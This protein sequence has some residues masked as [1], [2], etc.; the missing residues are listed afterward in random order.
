VEKHNEAAAQKVSRKSL[1]K[2]VELLRDI[3]WVDTTEDP[4]DKRK[5]LV[6]ALKKPESRLYYSLRRSTPFFHETDLRNWLDSL[7]NYS[8]PETIHV[9]NNLHDREE[10]PV[11]GN[12]SCDLQNH[13]VQRL[14]QDEYF[15]E[16]L[17]PAEDSKLEKNAEISRCEEKRR[18]SGISQLEATLKERFTWGTEQDFEALAQQLNPALT[19]AEAETLFWQLVDAG[20]IARDPDGWWRWIP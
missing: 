11:F 13:I 2:Y 19:E 9:Y 5:R 18:I 8:S 12:P 4:D 3:G 7:K 17:E 6:Y 16:P 20:A 10:Q 14:F 1:Y 15:L